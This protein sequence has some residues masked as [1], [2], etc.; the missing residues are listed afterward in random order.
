[1]TP[2]LLQLAGYLVTG[3]TAGLVAGL[4]G[5]GGGTLIV[6]ALL[7]LFYLDG[8]NPVFSMQLAISTSLATIVF[9]NLS[10]TWHHHRR[11]SVH[12]PLVRHYAPGALLGAWLGAQL[13]AHMQGGQ[14]RTLFGLFEIC[15]GFLMILGGHPSEE[16]SVQAQ[17]VVGSLTFHGFLSLVI[18]I[19]STLFGI[20]GGTMLVPALTLIARQPIHLAIGSSS[21]L[22]AVLALVGTTG[23]IHAG[24]ANHALP[25]HTMGFVVPLAATGIV[26][27][28]L[29]TTPMG[30]KLAHEMPSGVLKKGFGFLLVVVGIKMLWS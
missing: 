25:P 21:A 22:G 9:T 2:L 10:A 11:D 15:V 29:I 3:L 8:I 24:W 16:K 18:G 30:V 19:V 13:A 1:M 28:T 12:W 20:G 27:G 17:P 23:L 6:P 5:V 14:L 26:L 7:F 4:F